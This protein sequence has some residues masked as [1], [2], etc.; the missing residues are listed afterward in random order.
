MKKWSIFM[1]VIVVALVYGLGL[2][3]RVVTG[4]GEQTSPSISAPIYAPSLN[5]GSELVKREVV[6]MG[7]QFVFVV[8]APKTQALAAITAV[9]ERLRQLE[10]EISSWKPGSDVFRLN[11]N[12]GQFIKVGADTLALLQLAQKVHADTDGAFDVSIGAVW[13]LYPFRHQDAPMPGDQQIEARLQFVGADKIQLRVDESRAMVPAGMKINFGGI[14]KGYAAHIAIEQMQAMGINNAAVSAGGD[15]FL[16]GQKHTGPWIV[17]I[18]NPLW[19]GKTIEQFALQNCSAATSGDA[20][21]YFIRN[22]KRYGHIISPLT[23]W[24]VEGIR[25]VTVIT[26]DP[27]LA[28]AYATAVFVKGPVEGMRWVNARDGVEALIIDDNGSVTRS[29]GWQALTGAKP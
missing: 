3:E 28:D 24:P 20:Q 15:V 23:G 22:G 27:T 4:H 11:D 1:L 10:A 26:D 13:D 5:E 14:G 21:R 16:L 2:R 29:T 9:T 8:D 19:P 17:R 6:L 7:S 25:S 18:E 12:T